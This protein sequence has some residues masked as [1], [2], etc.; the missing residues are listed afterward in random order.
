MPQLNLK[1]SVDY[2][3]S[4]EAYSIIGACME[5]HSYLGKGFL[6]AVYKDALQHEFKLK[7]I[8]FEREKRFE[9]HY[10][11]E[12]LTHYYVS[13]FTIDNKIILEVKAQEGAIE[14]HYKQVINYLAIS[15]YQLGI[16]VNFGE[17]SLTYRRVVLNKSIGINNK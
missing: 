7:G 17:D 2:P 12:L 10:K 15:G 3:F 8:Q 16:L 11:D 1:N 5:V 6:E 4:E 13:D 9:I 14:N